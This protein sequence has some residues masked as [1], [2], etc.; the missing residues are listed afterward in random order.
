MGTEGQL[1]EAACAENNR[2][3]LRSLAA[4]ALGAVLRKDGDQWGY[5]LGENLAEGCC[6]FG[7]TP[8]LAALAFERE[9][10]GHKDSP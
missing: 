4:H 2:A 10:Y 9:Y 3:Q 5:L 7:A 8:H 6:G 1:F